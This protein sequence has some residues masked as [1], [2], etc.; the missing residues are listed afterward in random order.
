MRSLEPLTP[1]EFGRVLLR[2]FEVVSNIAGIKHLALTGRRPT[3]ESARPQLGLYLFVKIAKRKTLV[4]RHV[5]GW[6]RHESGL[7]SSS[8]AT[9]IPTDLL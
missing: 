3:V 9:G 4:T 5:F 7:T 8:F 2:P 1:L 6:T